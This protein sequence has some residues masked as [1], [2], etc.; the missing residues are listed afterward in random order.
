MRLNQIKNIAIVTARSGS[1]RIKNKNIKNFFGKPIIFYSINILKKT[2]IF[3]KIILTT[4]SNKISKISKKFGV[5]I[6][7]KRSKNLSNNKTGTFVVVKDCLKKLRLL[8]I[9]PKFV[10]CMYP[11]APITDYK[12]ILMSYKLLNKNK[13]DFIFPSTLKKKFI[14]KKILKLPKKGKIYR[15]KNN[16]FFQDAGQF[17]FS[18]NSLW[19]K[20]NNEIRN[21]MSTFL[22]S[23]EFSDINTKDDWNKVKEIFKN[24]YKKFYE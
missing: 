24:K 22:I 8:G 13:V 9:T 17:Y 20:N 18:K 3:D 21:R 10:C 12:N 2:G 5:D 6:I 4:N 23:E 7:I 14:D 11:A 16:K 19:K 1:V 15:L